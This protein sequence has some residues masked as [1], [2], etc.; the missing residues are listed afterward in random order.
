MDYPAAAGGTIRRSIPTYDLASR[1]QSLTYNGTAM[2]TSPVYN[3]SSQT[4]QLN[5]GSALQEQY[6]F[7]PKTGLL[8]NQKVVQGAT[9]HMDLS[10]DYGNLYAGGNATWKTGQL[11]KIIDNKITNGNRNREY[12][13][14]KLGR[15]TQVKGG[16]NGGLWNQTYSYDWWG[17][18]TGITQTGTSGAG[19]AFIPMDGLASLSYNTTTNRITT[20]SFAYD[21]AGNQTQANEN[22]LVNNYKYDAAGR[23]AEVSNSIGIHTY[24]YGASNQRLQMVEDGTNGG[25]TLYVWEG[26]QVIAEYNG[27]GSG[28][29][30]TKSYVYLGGRL[31]AT[32]STSGVQYHHPDRLGTRLVTNTSGG[33]VSENIGLPFGNTITGES[34]NLAGSASKKRFTSYDRSDNTKLDYAVNRHYSAAQGRFT[35]V[36]PIGMNAVS[37]EDPQSLNLYAYCINDP[38]NHTDPDGLFL[39]KLFG[40][41]GKAFK[42]VFRIAA[43]IVAVIA[44]MALGAIGQYW[45][46]ILITKG[47]VAALFA[48]SALLA[49]AGWAPG[50]V[51]QIAGAIIT[52]GLSWGSNARTPSTFP[53]SIGAVDNYFI[54][55]GGGRRG[56]GGRGNP[57]PARHTAWA[58]IWRDLM[59]RTRV[60]PPRPPS[61]RIPSPQILA[62]VNQPANQ[63]FVLHHIFPQQASLRPYF[64]NAGINVHESTVLIPQWLHHNLHRGGPNGG[65]WNTSWNG[66][67]Q[68][69]PNATRDQ[70]FREANRMMRVNS[71]H[72]YSIFHY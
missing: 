67:F 31:L 44:V 2:A 23:L 56:G 8:T 34:N 43:V 66:F 57:P 40:G 52:A 22:G 63:P 9:T 36:D 10:Y 25:T 17:N 39:R 47:L 14:D 18:R 19:G 46:S 5:I 37:L 35:Q 21:A 38:I 15:L 42:W 49:T 60:A 33:I 58:R 61:P 1:L 54:Q 16:P 65:Y 24:A 28:M 64:T 4:T 7:D 30:W 26:G 13:Y 27:V 20:G 53:S 71:V 68:Q 51:G 55:G 12:N 29:A 6:T 69:Y 48:S 59:R 41:I 62:T 70:I 72:Q 32:D 45:G 3:A 11:S 50:I